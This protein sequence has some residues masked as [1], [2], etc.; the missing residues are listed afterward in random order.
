[1]FPGMY[2]DHG[3]PRVLIGG[4]SGRVFFLNTANGNV[5]FVYQ[6]AP[7][8]KGEVTVSNGIVYIPVGNG[9]LTALGQ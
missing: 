9:T 2:A 4:R 5:L 7:M 6:V 3:G 8:V 1:M